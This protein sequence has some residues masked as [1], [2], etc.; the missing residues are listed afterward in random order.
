[1]GTRPSLAVF[2]KE[3]GQ[4]ALNG[5][6]VARNK[7]IFATAAAGGNSFN[8]RT[9]KAERRD[10]KQSTSSAQAFELFGDFTAQVQLHLR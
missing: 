8:F 3:Q 1:M 5:R 4:R 2:L 7:R 9:K 6:C 10:G